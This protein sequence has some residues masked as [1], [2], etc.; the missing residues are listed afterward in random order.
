MAKTWIVV[1][2]NSRARLFTADSPIAPLQE[3]RT[4]DHP[5]SRSHSQD[6]TSDLP[7]RVHDSAGQ[8]RH[9]YV[10]DTMPKEHEG[11]MFAKEVADQLEKAR[12]EHRIGK[13]YIIAG[14]EFLGRLRAE[15]SDNLQR[16]VAQEITKNLTQQSADAIRSHLPERL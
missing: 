11:V 13:L 3:V 7:G 1:A 9:A 6:L 15:L 16:L 5:Q 14:P 2:E 8:G 4:L 10:E 12:L